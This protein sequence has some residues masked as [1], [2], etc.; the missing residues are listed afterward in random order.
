[1]HSHASYAWRLS[2]FSP[3]PTKLISKFGYERN[4]KTH[5]FCFLSAG[6]TNIF[7]Q[8]LKNCWLGN[9][10]KQKQVIVKM[11]CFIFCRVV[12]RML[13]IKAVGHVL[14]KL[15]KNQSLHMQFK[16]P[17]ANVYNF[18]ASKTVDQQ[19]FVVQKRR[20]PNIGT[21]KSVKC[22]FVYCRSTWNARG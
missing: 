2:E 6:E 17:G 14:D 19:F 21:E 10:A 3:C 11:N 9:E 20:L 5:F 15:G 8:N 22:R 1:M 4:A 12:Y 7:S 13:K 16:P 18:Q